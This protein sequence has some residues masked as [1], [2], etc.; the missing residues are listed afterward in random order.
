ML[1]TRYPLPATRYCLPPLTP[2]AR[3]MP[4]ARL[5]ATRYSLLATAVAL[6]ATACVFH[7]PL[8][9]D[10]YVR[11]VTSKIVTPWGTSEQ[12]LDEAATGTAARNASQGK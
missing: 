6:G 10:A 7:Q 8:P 4:A 5:L 11:G 1:A 2:R 3:V 9:K 12:H